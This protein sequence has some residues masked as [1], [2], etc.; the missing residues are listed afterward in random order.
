MRGQT[1]WLPPQ[2]NAL[3]GVNYRGASLLSKTDGVMVQALDFTGIGE[4]VGVGNSFE[5]ADRAEAAKAIGIF[6]E[7][8]AR[9]GG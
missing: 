7:L 8:F 5:H 9:M 2:H 4:M 1:N 6:E 3:Y